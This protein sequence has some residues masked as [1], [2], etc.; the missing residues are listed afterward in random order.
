MPSLLFQKDEEGNNYFPSEIW[1]IDKL[2]EL[3]KS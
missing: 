3:L 1:S 2:K